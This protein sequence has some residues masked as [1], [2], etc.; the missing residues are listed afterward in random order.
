M[1]KRVE[2]LMEQFMNEHPYGDSMELA[3]YMYKKGHDDGYEDGYLDEGEIC[4]EMN[5]QKI[6]FGT[7]LAIS[8]DVTFNLETL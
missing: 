3:E 8:I 2:K 4:D 6:S 7:I 5:K 1:K